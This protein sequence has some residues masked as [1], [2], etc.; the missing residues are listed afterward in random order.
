L[1]LFAQYKYFTE[2]RQMRFTP[3][4]QTLYALKQAIEELKQEGLEQRCARYEESWNTLIRGLNRLGLKYLVPEQNHSK[5]VTSIMEPDCPG[6]EFQEMHDFFYA[7]G[8]TIYP[9]KLANCNTF[10]IANIGDIT[11]KDIAAFLTLLE[12]YLAG[13]GY[14]LGK[15]GN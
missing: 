10:R 9:G 15:A 11:H 7:R 12:Q 1:N 2:T 13:I 4:V 6:Y 14:P 5:I 3:P 8:F